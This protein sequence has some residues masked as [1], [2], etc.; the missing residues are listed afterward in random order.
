MSIAQS[1]KLGISHGVINPHLSEQATIFINP[2]LDG[3]CKI[4]SGAPR[5]LGLFSELKFYGF[6]ASEA[7]SSCILVNNIL[8]HVACMDQGRVI[9]FSRG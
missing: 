5:W 7:T 4:I 2:N 9:E 3:S 8:S 6:P 1:D